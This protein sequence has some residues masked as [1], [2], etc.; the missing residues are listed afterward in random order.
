MVF[1]L[2]QVSV[3]LYFIRFPLAFFRVD[4]FP[5]SFFLSLATGVC[6]MLRSETRLRCLTHFSFFAPRS[7]FHGEVPRTPE[8]FR[9]PDERP[10][11]SGLWRHSHS[12]ERKR[13]DVKAAQHGIA[14]MMRIKNV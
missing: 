9:T 14:G 10:S 5:Y 4:S 12:S 2:A 1:L 3:Y 6:F 7:E 13:V 8:P 11:R